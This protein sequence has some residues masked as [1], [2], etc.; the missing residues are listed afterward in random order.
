MT[1][2]NAE[3]RLIDLSLLSRLITDSRNDNVRIVS[4]R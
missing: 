3:F 4:L 2:G 1:S